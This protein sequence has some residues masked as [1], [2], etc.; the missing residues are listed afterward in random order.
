MNYSI[1]DQDFLKKWLQFPVAFEVLVQIVL[2]F[3]IGIGCMLMLVLSSYTIGTLSLNIVNIIFS[4]MICITVPMFLIN[5]FEW[6]IWSEPFKIIGCIFIPLIVIVVILWHG[7]VQSIVFTR[8][9]IAIVLIL[10]V[11][12][13]I[14]FLTNVIMDLDGIVSFVI[15]VA[16]TIGIVYLSIR[17]PVEIREIEFLIKLVVSIIIGYATYTF[18]NSKQFSKKLFEGYNKE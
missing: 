15:C 7:G 1:E 10:F 2:P 8:I 4:L 16:F 17:F 13:I 11:N 12:L 6:E 3:L 9:G 18:T 5:R 14:V